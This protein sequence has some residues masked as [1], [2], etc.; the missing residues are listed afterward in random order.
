MPD[1]MVRCRTPMWRSCPPRTLSS[2]S[3]RL[4]THFFDPNDLQISV[5]FFL[6]HQPFTCSIIES[7]IR[8]ITKF[9]SNFFCDISHSVLAKLSQKM[10]RGCDK[11]LAAVSSYPGCVF[12][13]RVCGE[14]ISGI[15]LLIVEIVL[16]FLPNVLVS[17]SVW[18][19]ISLVKFIALNL[20]AQWLLSM[21]DNVNK[22]QKQ[23]TILIYRVTQN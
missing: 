20:F 14:I 9:L 4:R 1:S 19:F 17:F 11:T 22:E 7:L 13:K 18:E 23:Y 3:A 21:S 8:A 5:K 2:G 10:F 15:V 6:W 12:N 16:L